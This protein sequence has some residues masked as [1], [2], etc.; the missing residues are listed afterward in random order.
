MARSQPGWQV[1]KGLTPPNMWAPCFNS[2][3]SSSW[4]ITGQRSALKKEGNSLVSEVFTVFLPDPLVLSPQRTPF[5]PEEIQRPATPLPHFQTAPVL[6]PKNLHLTMGSRPAPS[7]AAPL[8]FLISHQI[9]FISPASLFL[10]I[11][12]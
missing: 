12:P 5:F 8:R 3:F 6:V 10:S 1:Q 4:E 7:R 2:H 11:F 9:G